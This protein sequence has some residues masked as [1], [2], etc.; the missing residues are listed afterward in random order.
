[1]SGILSY[2]TLVFAVRAKNARGGGRWAM[3]GKVVPPTTHEI[4]NAIKTVRVNGSNGCRCRYSPSLSL[5]P[6]F[7]FCV[8]KG[9]RG[10]EKENSG[11]YH[12]GSSY[13][14]SWFE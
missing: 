1:M 7:S 4:K 6:F 11:C 14:G 13:H 9:N 8:R 10:K 3:G 5:S 2:H 12:V